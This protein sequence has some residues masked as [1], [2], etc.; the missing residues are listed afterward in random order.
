MTENGARMAPTVSHL[1]SGGLLLDAA[2]GTFSDETQRLI[3][4]L[5][6]QA[7]HI[8][9]VHET[10]PGMNNLLVTF[11]ALEVTAD[12]LAETL[13]RA[14]AGVEPNDVQ[15]K[16]VEVPV[17]YGGQGGE[18]L[19]G[20]AAHCGLSPEEAVRRHAASRYSVAAIGAMPG[21]PY[22]SGLDPA[23]ARPRRSS[24]RALVPE[25]AVIIGGAQAGIMPQ[26]APSGWHIL[27]RT[28][29]KLFDAGADQPSLLRPGDLV[30]FSIAGI[31]R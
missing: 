2:H 7:A 1:G 16:T 24:P 13:R 31:E 29:I 28:E 18:D 22:L 26:A 15:G 20:W 19:D 5:A 12:H 9:G 21:F 3:W 27:G 10:V 17:I 23:L 4:A 6:S 14:W 30:R 25:G 8:E 11:D